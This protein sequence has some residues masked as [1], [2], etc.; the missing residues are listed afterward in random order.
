MVAEASCC[1]LGGGILER[2]WKGGKSGGTADKRLAAHP[3]AP[4]Q[5]DARVQAIKAENADI[6]A[7]CGAGQ[8][9]R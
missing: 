1:L 4:L 7:K 5:T 6:L 8:L 3:P 9:K 2:G